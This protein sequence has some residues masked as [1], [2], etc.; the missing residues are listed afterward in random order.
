MLAKS[1]KDYQAVP[2]PVALMAKTFKNGSTTGEHSHPCGQVLYAT[3][4]MMLARTHAG[5][6]AVPTGH[7]LLVP[8]LLFHDIEMHGR[9]EMLTAYIAA[10]VATSFVPGVCRVI[11]VS[12]FLDILFQ[13]MA[14]EPLLYA[15]NSRGALMSEL[16]IDEVKSAATTALALPMP[17]DKKLRWLCQHV[18]NDPRSSIGIDVWAE[19]IGFSRR[20]LTRRFREETGLSFG[21]WCR[22]WRQLRARA[23]EAEGAPTKLV[24][25]QVG[26]QSPQALRAMMKRETSKSNSQRV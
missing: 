25:A 1:G 3:S 9:V 20:T 12:K 21:E 14:A 23:L 7:A 11:L 15:P 26:Y 2:R 10:D 16:I 13:T 18:I 4:G 22:R 8:P 6:W 19:R 24:A 5:A 17:Q